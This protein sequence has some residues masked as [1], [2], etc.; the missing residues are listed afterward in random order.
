MMRPL[1]PISLH[2]VA[3]LALSVAIGVAQAALFERQV[4]NLQ[5]EVAAAHGEGKQLAVLLTLPDCPGCLEMERR[6]YSD[7][8]TEKRIGRR[9]RTVRLDLSRSGPITDPTGRATNP[10]ELAKRLRAVATPS[11]VFFDGDGSF[12]YRYTGTLDKAGLQNLA[13]Y[14]WRAKFEAFPF[15][16]G[17]EVSAGLHA[18]RPPASLPHYPEFALGATDGRQRSLADFRERVVALAVGYT[19]CPDVC[20]TTL[21]ELKTAVEALPT[22]QRRQ[23]QIL[24]ATLDPE[25]DHLAMLKAY[26]AAFAPERGRPILGLRGDPPA[27]ARLVKQL[28]LVVEKQPSGSTSYS[29]DHT[30][31]VFLFDATGRLRGISPF[32]QN[33]EHLRSDITRLLF[34]A[35]H[36]QRSAPTL[37]QY[38]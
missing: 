21:L 29:L 26:V 9:F 5:A 16:P 19:Q 1:P 7:K 12:R 27:T 32:G 17:N 30:A 34:E 36:G 3:G 15:S 4:D 24:F 37:A 35:S 18:S 2:A 8:A 28:Q 38:P 23:V 14:V 6:V 20:P 10:A 13:D 11:F 31:G 25:H 22:A 33:V